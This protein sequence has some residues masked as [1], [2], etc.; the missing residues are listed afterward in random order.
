MWIETEILEEW[1]IGIYKMSIDSGRLK[2]SAFHD[3]RNPVLT[4]KEIGGRKVLFA[5][6][7][8]IIPG[9]K[10]YYLFFEIL[11]DNKGCIGLAGSLDGITWE[12]KK[13]VLEEPFHLSYPHV[14]NYEGKYYMLPESR[15][16]RSVRL[17][18][19]VDFPAKWQL[20]KTL[21]QGKKFADPT[22]VRYHDLFWLF[23]ADTSNNSLYLYYSESLVGAWQEH[24]GNPVIRNNMAAARPGGQ[25]IHAGDRLIRIAQDDVKTYGQ[26]VRAFEIFRLDSRNYEEREL[27]ESPLL[28]ASGQ[29]WNKDGMHHL[30]VTPIGAEEWIA[31]VDGKV[32]HKR[33]KLCAFIPEFANKMVKRIKNNEQK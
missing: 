10:G 30:S 29:G 4:R 20:V 31:A 3:T 8:F 15:Q 9:E 11:K 7:P 27:P 25:I 1:S 12:Y 22:L 23:V 19:A 17:Y 2:I 18:Q 16:E 24:P 28:K 26:A 5:A 13:V 33:Y 6:D 21:I 14:F 32:H